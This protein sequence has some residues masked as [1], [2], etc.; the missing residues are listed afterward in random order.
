MDW[1]YL[2]FFLYKVGHPLSKV[3]QGYIERYYK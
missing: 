1:I 3:K 2:E